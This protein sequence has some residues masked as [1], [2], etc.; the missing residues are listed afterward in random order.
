MAR[1]ERLMADEGAVPYGC[2]TQHFPLIEEVSILWI[3]GLG[4]DAGTVSIT[5][6]SRDGLGPLVDNPRQRL[7]VIAAEIGC[8]RLVPV[9][10]NLEPRSPGAKEWAACPLVVEVARQATQT[11]PIVFAIHADPVGLG[12]VASL[13]RPGGNITGLS[14]LLTELAAKELQILKEAVPHATRIGV[15]W[16]P[17]T[18]SHP[19]ALEAVES[20][21]EKL[22]VQLHIA[23]VQTAA[24]FE[25]AFSA[26]TRERVGAFLSGHDRVASGAQIGARLP[27]MMFLTKARASLYCTGWSART[28]LRVSV[29]G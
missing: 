18:P 17:T 19:R 3:T 20:A 27:Q 8:H 11:I 26:M 24:D 6:G 5:A 22:G 15:L 9:A 13:A 28:V 4:C 16:N 10:R 29:R 21:G 2:K 14:M 1:E 12:H 23:P 25:G 7:S